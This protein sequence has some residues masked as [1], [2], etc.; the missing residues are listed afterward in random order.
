[1]TWKR[2]LIPVDFSSRSEAALAYGVG[3]ARLSGATLDVLH[4]VQAPTPLTVAVD[5]YFHNRVGV[6]E[7]GE[8]DRID[9]KLDALISSVHSNGVH[10]NKLIEL[11]S[12]AATTVRIA[13]EGKHDLILI[14]THGRVG[15]SELFLGSVAKEL[16]SGSPCPVLTLRDEPRPV[17]S[18]GVA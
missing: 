2:I 12:P 10:I 16:V 3:L 7:P 14:G 5:L 15:V 1:M 9:H 18:L 8:L 4:V 13:T 11:G 17:L 6:I